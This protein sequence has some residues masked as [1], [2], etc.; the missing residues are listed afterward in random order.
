[1]LGAD[2][3][4]RALAVRD[5]SDPARGAHAVQ[6]VVDTLVRALRA[7]WNNRVQ[8]IRDHPLVSVEDNYERLG[9]PQ[10]AVSRDARYTRYVS[11]TC[12]LRSHTSAMIP[13]LCGNWRARPATAGITAGVTCCWPVRGWS[14]GATSSTGSTPAPRTSST[15]GASSPAGGW[16]PAT[17]RR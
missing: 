9:Y 13:L 12:M 17:S 10:D 4:A 14:T 8:L 3:L 1:M 6:L 7:S 11:R 16:T 15:S 5:L 2:E